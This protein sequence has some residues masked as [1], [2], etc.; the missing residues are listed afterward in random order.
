MLSDE[1]VSLVECNKGD[2]GKR[3]CRLRVGYKARNDRELIP[4]FLYRLKY[5]TSKFRLSF[6][7]SVTA[8]RTP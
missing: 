6:K 7:T 1:C 4:R 5:T 8:S 2:G 3:L